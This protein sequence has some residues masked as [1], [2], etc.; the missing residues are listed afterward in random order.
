MDKK[1]GIEISKDLMIEAV[2][3]MMTET[4]TAAAEE[5]TVKKLVASHKTIGD[6]MLSSGV[7]KLVEE[8]AEEEV[9]RFISE[10]VY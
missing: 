10:E 3:E 5:Y 1:V 2:T 8:I 6:R 9:V 4:M 7:T